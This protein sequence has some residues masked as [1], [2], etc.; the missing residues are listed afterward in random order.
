MNCPKHNVPL[1][2]GKAIKQTWR[3]GISDSARIPGSIVTMSV[4]G[5]GRL[6]DCLKCKIC[7]YSVTA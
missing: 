6:I 7:G 3:C 1:Q 2:P 4:G 5:P